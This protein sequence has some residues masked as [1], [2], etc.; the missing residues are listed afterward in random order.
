[1][2]SAGPALARTAVDV[3]DRAFA[4]W[5]RLSA[6]Q[7]AQLVRSSLE[8]VAAAAPEL[9]VLLTRENGK[10][11]VESQIDLAVFQARC[12]AA[13]DLADSF[14]AGSVLPDG[15]FRTRV[16][17]LPVGVVTIIVPFNWPPA[18]LAASLPYAL[19]AGNTVVVKPPPTA[20][21]ALTRALSLMAEKLPPGVLNVVNGEAAGVEPLLTDPRVQHVVFTGSTAAGRAVMAAAAES[22]A[23]VTLELGG[24]DPAV[25]LDETV[26]DASTIDALLDAA[27]MSTGQVCMAVKRVYVP[28][29]CFRDVAEAFGA[30]L[31]RHRVGPGLS[32]TTTLGP[33]NR[34]GTRIRDLL[35]E[36]AAAG[37][38]VRE[39]GEVDPAATG[40]GHYLRPALVLDPAP[41]LRVV[42]QEQ[43]GPVLPVLPYDDLDDLVE[44]LNGEWSGL[45]SSVWSTDLDRAGAVADRMRF[46]TTWINAANAG[47]CDD[48]A[49]FGGFRQSG[50]GR[51]MGL[52]GL[53]EFTEPHVVTQVN[54]SR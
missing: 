42:T 31:E 19:V 27:F 32:E 11:L 8:P 41:D 37:A 38:E 25:L 14:E 54:V 22:L 35:A 47:A 5:A 33:L 29:R 28:R 26:P 36:A 48:R 44:Q 51:E 50:I 21:L 1:V 3:A 18:I 15:P 30:D 6:V 17:R 20:P 39:Y 2:G 7:R 9:A 52:D 23:R 24:N 45:C 10:V 12:R 13:A 16:H 4:G 43:F 49:P 46:G 40:E 53:T 34:P